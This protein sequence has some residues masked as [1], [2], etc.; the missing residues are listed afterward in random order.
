MTPLEQAEAV[1]RL[2][3]LA[4]ELEDRLG[5]CQVKVDALKVEYGPWGVEER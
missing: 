2:T 1:A 3:V 5:V 4:G